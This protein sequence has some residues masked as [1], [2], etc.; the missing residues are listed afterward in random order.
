MAK[1]GSCIDEFGTLTHVGDRL[2]FRRDTGG[3]WNIEGWPKAE[4]ELGKLGRPV[5]TV[6]DEDTVAIERFTLHA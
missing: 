4:L 6:V 3:R 1:I 5:G 2:T